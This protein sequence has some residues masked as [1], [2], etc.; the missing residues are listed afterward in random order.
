M[1]TESLSHLV[2]REVVLHIALPGI[3]PRSEQGYLWSAGEIPDI[4][5]LVVCREA[6]TPSPGVSPVGETVTKKYFHIQLIEVSAIV[7]VEIFLPVEVTIA[8]DGFGRVTGRNLAKIALK[9]EPG[10]KT[11]GGAL[12][13]H[14]DPEIAWPLFADGCLDWEVLDDR[15]KKAVYAF[16]RAAGMEKRPFMFRDFDRTAP[17]AVPVPVPVPVR[18]PVTDLF[19]GTGE[20]EEK[21]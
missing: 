9:R 5:V 3:P 7:G 18:P 8:G 13:D 19:G 21:E 2:G 4:V 16:L 11:T 17:S 6:A 15:L 10:G 14:V 1:K 12:I 20:E